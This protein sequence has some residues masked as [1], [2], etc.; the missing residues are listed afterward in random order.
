LDKGQFD[1]AL[2]ILKEYLVKNPDSVDACSLLREV[3]WRKTDIPLYLA[4]TARLCSQHLAARQLQAAW[5]D[6]EEFLQQ[7]G[8]KLPA[9]PGSISVAHP[10]RRAR[11]TAR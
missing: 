4:Y 3:H 11:S 9:Q 10:K 7:G 2:P 8:D 5:Q 1:Q 6:Y